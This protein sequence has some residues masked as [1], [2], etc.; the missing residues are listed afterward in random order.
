MVQDTQTDGLR[1]GVGHAGVNPEC[2]SNCGTRD[3]PA[4]G[5]RGRFSVY[6]ECLS[7]CGT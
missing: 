6:P 7:T 2:P 1:G 5:L 3:T 4:V